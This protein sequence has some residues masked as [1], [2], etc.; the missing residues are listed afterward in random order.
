MKLIKQLVYEKKVK[1]DELMKAADIK[2]RSTITLKL[3][4]TYSFTTEEAGKIK[5]Y[6]N[7]KLQTNYTIDELFID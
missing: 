2:S 6:I 7:D 5:K 3:N 4:G 1:H